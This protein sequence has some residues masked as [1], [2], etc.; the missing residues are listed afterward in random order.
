M[1]KMLRYKSRKTLPRLVNCSQS[2]LH[3]KTQ[4][5]IEKISG[6]PLETI[7]S[8]DEVGFLSKSYTRRG[9]FRT[10]IPQELIYN[11]KRQKMSCVMA[12]TVDG[13]LSYDMTEPNINKNSF[14]SFFERMLQCKP[15]HCKVV[16]MDNISFHKSKEV[17]ELATKYDVR[18]VHT[19]PYSP[20]FNPIELVFSMVKRKFKAMLIR[21]SFQSSVENSIKECIQLPCNNKFHH[22]FISEIE[23][24]INTRS[25][26]MVT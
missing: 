11:T 13:V 25:D 6:V 4:E 3:T 7:I 21:N 15:D 1:L 22:C 18:I 12:I 26:D 16:V 17:Y 2:R 14:T 23:K 10:P 8:I 5:F 24:Y 9:F 19:P 20:Q